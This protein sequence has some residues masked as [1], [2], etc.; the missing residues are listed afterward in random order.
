MHLRFLHTTA[1]AC[2]LTFLGCSSNEATDDTANEETGPQF[3]YLQG[4]SETTSP[5]G[6]MIYEEV[7]VLAKKTID[8]IAGTIVEDTLHGDEARKTFF[9]LQPGTLIFDVTDEENS[10]S[11]TVTFESDDWAKSNLT[12]NLELFGDYPGTLTGTG[13]W[14]ADTYITDKEFADPEGVVQARTTE[15][16]TLITEEEYSAALPE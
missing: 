7:D 9:T 1:T 15:E 16:L 13:T 4:T 12:Y 14:E 3:Q 11:G 5:N 2:L 8:S 10:F 6:A